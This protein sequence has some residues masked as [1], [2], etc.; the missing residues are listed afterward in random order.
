MIVL[1][2]VGLSFALLLAF[3]SKKLKVEDDPL[4]SHILQHLPGANCG[5]CGFSGCR[6]FAEAAAKEKQLFKGCIPGGEKANSQIAR[7]LGLDH[8]PAAHRIVAACRCG[9]KAGEKKSSSRY[10]GPLTCRS[11]EI[12]RGGID[13]AYGCLGVGDCA[14]VCPVG[15][16]TINE[17]RV[18]V[19][20]AKCIGC[21]KCAKICPRDL[22]VLVAHNNIADY[23]VACSNKE[24]GVSVKQVCGKG[25]IACGICVRLPNSPFVLQDNLSSVDYAKVSSVQALEDAR[26]K[27]PTRCI[28][29]VDSED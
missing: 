4:V 2:L 15:A 3:L 12:T 25:C 6:A 29:K 10:H 23:Y 14:V 21:G 27:C 9:A 16:I 19:D 24:K 26:K 11:M 17:E 20:A 13:C 7:L 28:G 8:K 5:A 1:S 22:F 18:Y